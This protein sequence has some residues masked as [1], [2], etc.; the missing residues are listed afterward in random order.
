M[1]RNDVTGT[2]HWLKVLLEGVKSNR[3]AIGARVIAQYGNRKQALEVTAQSSFYS[4]ND[5]RLHF[6]LGTAASADV[7]VRWPNGAMERIGAVDADQLIVIREGAGV[8]RRQRF[9]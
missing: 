9:G 8:V 5:R 7:N 2:G 3:S 1:L 4:A 6:G